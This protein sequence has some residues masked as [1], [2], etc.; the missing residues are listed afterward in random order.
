M[1]ILPKK[2]GDDAPV[3]LGLPVRVVLLVL[4]FHFIKIESKKVI[5]TP[6]YYPY[7]STGYVPY[8]SYYSTT[9]HIRNEVFRIEDTIGEIKQKTVNES[10]I[11]KIH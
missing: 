3:P 4:Y 6:P 2:A 9:R 5:R 8:G 7:Y 11:Q 1:P 10:S